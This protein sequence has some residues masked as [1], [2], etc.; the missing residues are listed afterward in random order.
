M[1]NGEGEGEGE[2]MRERRGYSRYNVERSLLHGFLTEKLDS[3]VFGQ[4]L[5]RLLLLTTRC[6]M[7][8]MRCETRRD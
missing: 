5:T 3:L 1:V 8:D 4:D 7:Q 2:S 6:T